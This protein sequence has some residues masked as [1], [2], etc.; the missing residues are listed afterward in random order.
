MGELLETAT[1][2]FIVVFAFSLLFSYFGSQSSEDEPSLKPSSKTPSSSSLDNRVKD[3][4][5]PMG[6]P[7]GAPI[8]PRPPRH[9]VTWGAM[10]KPFHEY[11]NGDE[12]SSSWFLR[13]NID[14]IEFKRFLSESNLKYQDLHYHPKLTLKKYDNWLKPIEAE[15]LRALNDIGSWRIGSYV[16]DFGAPT[17]K[18]YIANEVS[19]TFSNLATND[20]YL[21][22]RV[23]VDDLHREE[24]IHFRFSMFNKNSP[25]T[26]YMSSRQ[27]YL[28]KVRD[29][30]FSTYSFSATLN[31]GSTEVSVNKHNQDTLL[32]LLKTNQQLRFMLRESDGTAVYRF[33]INTKNYSNARNKALRE[34]GSW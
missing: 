14:L 31:E 23:L 30:Y 8:Y 15:R 3:T 12:P 21:Y 13:H 27:D 10:N 24:K 25:V 2:A 32:S 9:D 4:R 22:A 6:P 34:Q 33:S 20:S 28:G 16:D 11:E 17:S 19:G 26:N 5:V 1:I 29:Q 7:L 18:K